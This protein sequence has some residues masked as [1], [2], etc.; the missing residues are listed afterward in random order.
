MAKKLN[1][2]ASI[3]GLLQINSS[4]VLSLKLAGL[5]LGEECVH[6]KGIH[7][8]HGTRNPVQDVRD[9]PGPYPVSVPPPPEFVKLWNCEASNLSYLFSCT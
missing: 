1:F 3:S 8:I 2:G 6:R 5:Y 4:R 9:P 7:D